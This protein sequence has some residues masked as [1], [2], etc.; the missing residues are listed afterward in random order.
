MRYFFIIGE[1]SGDLHASNLIKA[2][3]LKDPDAVIEGVGGNLSEKAGMV[4]TYHYEDLAIM[5]FFKV[6]MHLRTIKRNFQRCQD[7]ILA[8][9]PDAVVL[10][11]FPG[12]NLRMA[13]FAKENALKVF[14]YIAP[15]VWA[16]RSKRVSQIKAYTDKVFTIFPFENKFFTEHGV[17]FE[18]VGNPLLDSIAARP[19]KDETKADFLHRHNLPNKPIVAL[20]A[21]SRRQEVKKLLPKMLA[22]RE[23][24]P[25]CQFILAGVD[26][27]GGDFYTKVI[28]TDQPTIIY[29][30]TYAVLQHSDA[31]L[32]A[33]G[34]ATLE[35]ALLKIPQVVCYDI[36]GGKL[37]YKVY[38]K[39]MLNVQYV[40]LVNL[41]MDRLIVKEFLQHYFSVENLTEELNL[42]LNDKTYRQEMLDGYDNIIEKLGGEGASEKTAQSIVKRLK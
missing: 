28:P 18:Y 19:R 12:F 37:L 16:S 11:D 21:G 17:D 6:L 8:S 10:V 14:Y 29:D 3:K 30:E 20:L 23:R 42:L 40:S 13:K 5:G 35:T 36:G 2:I 39:F 38:K 41:I 27:L 32:V 9:K 1:R 15:K 7:A 33:S 25:E 4:L 31:A 24:F 26:N 22:L 34:T